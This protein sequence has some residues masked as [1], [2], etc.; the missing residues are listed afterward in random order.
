[1]TTKPED[2]AKILIDEQ[3]TTYAALLTRITKGE[4]GAEIT[5]HMIQ[6]DDTGT[7]ILPIMLINLMDKL[8]P[9]I[10]SHP[11]RE[12]VA[13]AIRRFLDNLDDQEQLGQFELK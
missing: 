11:E 4:E 9:T 7:N 2:L 10:K 1:M 6:A 12:K 3:D 5:I 8:S 13:K